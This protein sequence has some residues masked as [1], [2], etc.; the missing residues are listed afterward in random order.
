[1]HVG[2]PLDDVEVDLEQPLLGDP[3]QML[4]HP[5]EHHLLEL[6]R[7]RAFVPQIEIAHEL[8]GDRAGTAPKRARPQ[9]VGDRALDRLEVEAAV[10]KEGAVLVGDHRRDERRRDPFQWAEVRV[11]LGQLALDLPAARQ[12]DARDEWL[13]ES[14]IEAGAFPI[15][16]QAVRHH[17]SRETNAVGART[18]EIERQLVVP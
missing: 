8:H 11:R 15:Q 12:M 16:R 2:S 6:A 5:G 18:V 1:M 13:L 7:E 17:G 4:E 10:A 9:I 14:E 3:G